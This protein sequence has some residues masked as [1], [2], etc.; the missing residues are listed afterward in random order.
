[1]SAWP[2]RP[3]DFINFVRATNSA[4]NPGD[5]LPRKIYGQY[6]RRILLDLAAAA[7]DHLSVQVLHDEATRLLPSHCLSH[8]SANSNGHAGANSPTSSTSWTIETAG[9]RT[10]QADLCI[11]TVGHRPPNDPFGKRWIGPRNRFVADPWAALVLSQ[12]GPDEPVLLL[13]SGLTA[14]DAIL[15]LDR[16]GRVAPLTVI[17]R[18]GLMPLPHARSPQLPADLSN[19]LSQW[20]DPATPL[21][22]RHLLRDLRRQITAD[23]KSGT[24]WRQIIDALRPAITRL[25]GRLDS[26]QRSCFLRHLRPFWEIHRHRMAPD[27]AD[28]IDRL[29][30]KKIL[31]VA[32]GAV[33]SAV[34]DQQ[35]VDVTLSGRGSSP[36]RTLRVSWVINCTGPGAHNR[37]QTHPL[38][39]PLLEAGTICN[40]EFDLG[41][42]TD[43]LGRAVD[44]TGQS[45]PTLLVAG[46]LRKSTLW[47][48]TAVPELRQQAQTAAQ[49]AIQTLSP[50][51]VP[52][53]N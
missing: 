45:L 52:T 49:T 29:R 43:S 3:D 10:I 47:E 21:K 48:S 7:S 17:S 34:A 27:V 31:Q 8:S 12:I 1:M 51:R 41:L 19:L 6:V 40:D 14:V 26:L 25:W 23:Q 16:P 42:H 46:T 20:L 11:L 33:I 35:G 18:H 4:A 39:R 30:Q 13:G 22:I 53:E 44:S 24:D 5:F 37:H 28:T 50:A 9:G 15:T 38:L 2:D 32:A 36:R